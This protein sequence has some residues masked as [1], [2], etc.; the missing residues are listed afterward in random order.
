M[1]FG[2]IVRLVGPR[3]ALICSTLRD[4]TS[5]L[6]SK[7]F[8]PFNMGFQGNSLEG[9]A[10]FSVCSHPYASSLKFCCTA[11]TER[12][13][14]CSVEVIPVALTPRP[15]RPPDGCTVQQVALAVVH[16]CGQRHGTQLLRGTAT[17]RIGNPRE[18]RP[19]PFGHSVRLRAWSYE[20]S[21][22]GLRGKAYGTIAMHTKSLCTFS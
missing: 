6:E 1:Y 5:S 9:N 3:V 16:P 21:K 10:T 14:L 12:T 8:Y 4:T 22:I 7:G 18:N 20:C 13:R 11:S 15:S 2:G 17:Y 19:V